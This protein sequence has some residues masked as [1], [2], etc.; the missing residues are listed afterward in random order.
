MFRTMFS[1]D[2][3]LINQMDISFYKDD[4]SAFFT[5]TEKAKKAGYDS[6]DY[7]KEAVSAGINSL[8]TGSVTNYGEYYFVSVDVY[9]YPGGKLNRSI[10]EVGKIEDAD[11][12]I[13]MD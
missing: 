9:E 7:E 4:Q 13:V 12:I 10:S 5:P 11:F 8:I 1:K 6:F 2:A 3:V